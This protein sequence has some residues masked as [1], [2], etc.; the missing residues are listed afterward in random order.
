MDSQSLKNKLY[1]Q[2][3]RGMLELDLI[4]SHFLPSL[5]LLST[6]QLQEYERLLTYSDPEIYDWLMEYDKP[7]DEVKEI[8]KLILSKDRFKSSLK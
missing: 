3:R 4:L 1:W 7:K 6:N 2:S 5:E 8:V